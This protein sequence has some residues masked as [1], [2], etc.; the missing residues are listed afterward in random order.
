MRKDI[1]Y[2]VAAAL[3]LLV[4]IVGFILY[5]GVY[6]WFGVVGSVI[7]ITKRKA[8]PKI[9]STMLL[10]VSLIFLVFFMFSLFAAF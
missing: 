5:S 6:L 9:F 4:G 1:I 10:V 8:V 2:L 3:L 7:S